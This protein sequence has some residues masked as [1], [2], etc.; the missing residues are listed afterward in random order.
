VLEILAQILP[1]APATALATLLA[2]ARQPSFRIWA[3]NS[4]FELKDALKRRGYRWSDGSDGLPRCWYVDVAA[5][6]HSAEIAF[7]RVEIY[8]R[9]VAIQSRSITA[10]ERFS[11]RV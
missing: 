3:E 7:L 2:R 11:A 10:L 9:E 1:G 5:D 8:Q 4:P 6:R